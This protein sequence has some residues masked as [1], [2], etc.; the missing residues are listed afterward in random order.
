M[1]FRDVVGQKDVKNQLRQSLRKS[2]MPHARIFS[3][4]EGA[5]AF[6]LA[7]AY[8]RYVM[9][10][11]RSEEDSCGH[12]SSCLKINNL[13]HPDLHFVFPVVKVEKLKKF[14]SDDYIAEWRI[15][16]SKNTYFRLP[17]WLDAID[18]GNA[19]GLISAKE[20]DEV[21]KKLNFKSYESEYKIV[22]IWLPEKMHNTC[23]NKLLKMI[24]EPPAKTIFLMVS[25]A[26]DKIISTIQSRSQRLHVPPIMAEDMLL[27]LSAK[28]DISQEDLDLASIVRLSSGSYLKALE[29]IQGKDLAE[30]HLE[31]F[32]AIMRNSWTRNVIDMKSRADA[33]RN[34]GRDKQKSFLTYAQ[35]LLRQNF[36]ANFRIPEITYLSRTEAAFSQKFA[37]YIS[38]R[39]ILEFMEELALA[40]LHVEQNVNPRMIFFDLSL[41]IAVLLKK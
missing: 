27:A 9:C 41:K 11:N 5:G 39:N 8:A 4:A 17:S 33:F 3:G 21:I 31:F 19:Q 28:Y 14:V 18:A 10:E 16:L 20:G 26:P 24:E 7:L 2:Y 35:N 23:A 15:F 12:C 37:P 40:E 25:E 13:A 22:I 32:I 1:Y 34:M 29:A 6:P 38:E 36:I 30:A